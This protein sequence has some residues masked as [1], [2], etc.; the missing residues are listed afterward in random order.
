[1]TSKPGQIAGQ[2]S[3]SA[4]ALVY[5]TMPVEGDVQWPSDLYEVV[6]ALREA[7]GRLGQALTQMRSWLIDAE[8]AGNLKADRGD[9]A[10]RVATATVGF[11]D[12]LAAAD[13]LYDSLNL[14]QTGLSPIAWQDT[15][16][17]A[18]TR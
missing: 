11:T 17:R 8:A 14:A 12:A 13:A 10:E 16:G 9:L 15:D 5:S 7:S 2:I 18:G 4:H 1:M 3:D 6:G